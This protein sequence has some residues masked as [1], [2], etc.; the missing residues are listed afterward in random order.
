VRKVIGLDRLGSGVV[1]EHHEAVVVGG[2]HVPDA[3]HG[4]LVELDGPES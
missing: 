3:G 1:Y 2:E 4:A